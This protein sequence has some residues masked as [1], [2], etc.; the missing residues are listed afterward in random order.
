MIQAI[1]LIFA[2]ILNTIIGAVVATVTGLPAWAAILG[3]NAIGFVTPLLPLPAGLRVGVYTDAWT[4]EVV[5]QYTHKE[6]GTFL[7]GV[8]DYSR[9]SE[10][11]VIHLSEITTDPDVLIDN[12]T[13]PLEPTKLEDGDIAIKLAKFETQPTSVT[14]D[15]LYAISYDKMS[16]VKEVHGNKIGEAHLDKAIHAFAPAKHTTETPVIKTTGESDGTRKKITRKDVIA[17]RRLLDKLKVP[18]DGRRLVLCNDHV[19]DLLEDDQKF[20]NQYHNYET[21]AIAKMY[22]FEIYEY[23]NCPLYGQDLVKKAFGAAAADGDFEASVSFYAPRMF[24]AKG[25]TKVYY[26]EAGKDP[27]NKRNLI[28]F[29]SRFV[30]LPK[31]AKAACGAIVSTKATA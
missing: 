25:T 4:G 18:K 12:T 11:D 5:K 27:L 30:A 9:Y 20:M 14:D 29:T 7:D 31:Q 13:Y 3:V 21:G 2:V 22:G 19:N 8:P 24:K 16:V 28:S 26:S 15:E 23:V 17:L 6:Q 10:N 1:K